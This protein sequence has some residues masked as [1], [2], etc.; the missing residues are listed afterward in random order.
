M[1]K[2]E[3][4]FI[5]AQIAKFERWAA[6]CDVVYR[7]NHDEEDFMQY[8]LNDCSASALRNLLSGLDSLKEV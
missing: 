1:T 8:R 4:A 7:R 5:E 6:D 2:K 3:R